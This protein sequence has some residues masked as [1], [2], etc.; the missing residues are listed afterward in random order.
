[1]N[2]AQKRFPLLAALLVVLL[3]ACS[4]PALPLLTPTPTPTPTLTPTAT[5]RGDTIEPPPP[6]SAS[7]S[8]FDYSW[9]DR[10]PFRSNLSAPAQAVLD[11]L[12]GATVYHLAFSFGDP[13]N[14][15]LGLEEVR[16][17]N[18]EDVPLGEI[19]LAL[20]PNLLG[21]E[22][23]IR[24]VS[25][26]GE[27][28][29][30]ILEDWLMRLPL[31]PPLQP[32]EAV[33]LRVE[34]EVDIPS[35]GGGYYYGIF[36][37]NSGILSFAHAYPTVLVYN[38]EGWNSQKPDLDG[39]PLFADASFYLVS[40]DAPVGLTVVASGVEIE[41]LETGGRQRFLIANG[42]ARDFYLSASEGW[43]KQSQVTKNG[44]TVNSYATPEV[45]EES[46]LVLS[47]GAAA[48]ETFSQ[49]YGEYPY[50]E[51]D[52]API[53][54]EAGGVEYPGMTSIADD[55]FYWGSFLE[56]VVVHETAHMWFYNM[57]GNDTQDQPWLDESLAQFATWQYY[58]DR[59]GN[60]AAEAVKVGDLQSNWDMSDAPDTPIGLPVSAYPGYEYPAIV[61]GRGPFFFM[62][63]RD[64]MGVETFDRFMLDYARQYAWNISSTEAFKALAEQHCA[65]DLTPLFEEWVYP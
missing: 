30:P 13:P 48:I 15:A 4:C 55:A 53:F 51:F 21:G 14:H 40:V 52:I 41:R 8:P 56:I 11:M 32:G 6:I 12:P 18:T 46:Q 31:D 39:D 17:A 16:Y 35:G 47:Y 19:D 45:Q 44:V 37:Y 62:S 23:V 60:Q 59:Y 34:F 36:G 24:A 38:E 49:R 65:C 43:V 57:V 5:Q 26:D 64:Q 63:L 3:L 54:T 58:L 2:A 1:M 27:P 10:E 9:E 61:Y 7:E 28:A 20:F 42:P 22:M 29:A 50:T 33:T 25:L